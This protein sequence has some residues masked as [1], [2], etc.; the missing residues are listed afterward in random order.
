MKFSVLAT[1]IIDYAVSPTEATTN[2]PA[3]PI[4]AE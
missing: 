4:V 2:P 3:L 1:H